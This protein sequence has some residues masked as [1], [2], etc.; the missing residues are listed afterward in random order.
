M[1]TLLDVPSTRFYSTLY[2]SA[3]TVMQSLELLY[4]HV[5]IFLSAC[6]ADIEIDKSNVKKLSQ[7]LPHLWWHFLSVC[8]LVDWFDHSPRI[9]AGLVHPVQRWSLLPDG[10]A[11]SK[12]FRCSSFEPHAS[13]ITTSSHQAGL[14]PVLSPS[15][16]YSELKSIRRCL[17]LFLP[18]NLSL[19]I[20][21]Y[22]HV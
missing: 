20:F 4:L 12:S 5:V 9:C 2:F 1:G 22:R 3:C 13:Q 7:L 8:L 16:M 11:N 14:L 6:L 19:Y 18:C 17:L 10:V 21:F 15:P